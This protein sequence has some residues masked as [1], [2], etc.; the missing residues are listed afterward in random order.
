MNKFIITLMCLFIC[1]IGSAQIQ[2]NPTYNTRQQQM[3]APKSSSE[4]YRTTAY[5]LDE[6]G[7][8]IK[9]PI[10]VE[11]ISN[12]YGGTSIKVIQKYV[13]TGLGGNWQRVYSGGEASKCQSFVSSNPLESEFM[14]KVRIDTGVWYFDL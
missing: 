11:V 8:V 6:R 10:R 7:N 12:G 14:Y 13:N 3:N 5:S 9:M 1:T 4:S 2:Y